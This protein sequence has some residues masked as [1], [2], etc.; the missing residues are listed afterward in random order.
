MHRVIDIYG[1]IIVTAYKIIM[2]N[3]T[4]NKK[5]KGNDLPHDCSTVA[6]YLPT[7]SSSNFCIVT[8]QHD[9]TLVKTWLITIAHIVQRNNCTVLCTAS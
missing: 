3:F 1:R 6:R 2:N 5:I 8:L 7:F 4:S 9:T